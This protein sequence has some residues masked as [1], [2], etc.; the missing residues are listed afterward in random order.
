MCTGVAQYWVGICKQA[1]LHRKFESSAAVIAECDSAEQKLNFHPSLPSLQKDTLPSFSG[2][3]N[4][5]GSELSAWR[6]PSCDQGLTSSDELP[7][8][9][10]ERGDRTQLSQSTRRNNCNGLSESFLWLCLHQI[11]PPALCSYL[12]FYDSVLLPFSVHPVTSR[13]SFSDP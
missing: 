5:P 2:L 4:V 6:F 7:K 3:P 9:D 11:Q 12:T 13:C 1:Q 8:M 10:R